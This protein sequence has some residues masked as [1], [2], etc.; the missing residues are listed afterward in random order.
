MPI[1][2]L[3][4]IGTGSAGATVAQTARKAGKSV[5]IIDKLPF[6]GTCSQRGCDPKKVL[7][8]AA[9][10]VARSEQMTGNGIASAATINWPDL[11]AFKKTFTE[12]I[13]E[14]TEAKFRDLG[15]QF[16]HGVATFL[17]PKTVRVGQDELTADH[18]VV[19]TGQRPKPLNIP[20]E[21]LLIDS[22]GF[23]ELSQLP[24][25][26]VMVGG[27]YIAFEFAHIAAR[28][29]AKVTILHQGKR[30]LEGF[31]ADLVSLLVKAM[32]ALGIR[33][34]LEAN[35]TAV[36]GQKDRL[37]VRYEQAGESQSILTNLVIHAAGR[38]ADVAELAL[39]KAGV[40]VGPKGVAVNEFLQ[41]VSNPAI[42]AC[43]DVAD[44]GLPLTP[45]ASYEGKIAINNILTGNRQAY[46]DN[47]TPS[48]VYT[49]P[50]LAS[51]GLTEEQARKQGRKVKVTFQ[52]TNDWYTSRRINESFSA[53]KTL[54]DEETDEI[55]GAHLLGSGC[56]EV[57]N[58]FTLAMKHH[59]TA[60]DL[61]NTLL[62][63][64][65]HGSDLS[66]ML[67]D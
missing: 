8:G 51:V 32:E 65:T 40:K 28:A 18:I 17:S 20:G 47:P 52:E 35:V 45:L 7:V 1:F 19:A 37:T 43:G 16:Y 34:L 22:T 44:K 49:I 42:Y 59:I 25:E 63:Y 2:D 14:N 61:R 54:V 60:E 30:P 66:S 67:P 5:A 29:G 10:I 53:F 48:A 23:L 33:I 12:P 27:G 57:I 62:A 56:D 4:V 46:T 9:E 50:T 31:D 21:E 64:P 38:V 39:E 24:E 26:I 58:L 36:E 15:I 41:S 11:M 55:V 13:P 3:I 6:G